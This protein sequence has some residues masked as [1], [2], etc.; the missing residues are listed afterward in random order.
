MAHDRF[1]MPAASIQARQLRPPLLVHIFL[2]PQCSQST[3]FGA[4]VGTSNAG[5][6]MKTLRLRILNSCRE[7]PGARETGAGRNPVPRETP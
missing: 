1:P 6:G 2:P 4:I 3:S 7:A 5:T